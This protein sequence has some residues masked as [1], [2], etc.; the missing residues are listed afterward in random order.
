[1]SKK[2]KPLLLGA[3][4]SIAGGFYKAIERGESIGCTAI[5]IF[6]KSNR[7]WL[8]KPLTQEAI[9]TFIKRWRNSSIQT[10]VAHASYLINS[11]SST[12]AIRD[13][14]IE[15]LCEELSRCEQLEIPY[16]VLH[17]GSYGT[18]TESECLA[19][20][21]SSLNQ[22]FSKTPGKTT[23]LLETM[24]GQGTNVG[25]QFDHIAQIYQA[26]DYKNR[27]GVCLDTCHVFAAGYDFRTP[28]SYR[29]LWET[30]DKT[31]GLELLKVIHIND[32][33]KELGQKV[34][35]HEHIGKGKI[36]KS[37]FEL[38]FNDPK[39][40][41]IPKILETPKDSLVDDFNNMT[42]LCNLISPNT[43]KYLDLYIPEKF[44]VEAKR[45]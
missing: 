30:F 40:F 35:R 3:H 16:L 14:S 21:T 22:A 39:L 25:Y 26:S 8:A 20:I 24:A 31:I 1:M 15:S 23:I 7:Q 9:D 12:K 43:K 32:S 4:M 29:K 27:L 42:T 2:N 10:V 28:D 11:G 45:K 5:Q 38:I 44:S 34:D 36:G 41:D 17:P 19:I 18:L 33:K 37:A 13:K 6:T